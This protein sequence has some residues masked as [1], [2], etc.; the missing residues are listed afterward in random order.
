M[1]ADKKDI[2]E[3][4]GIGTTGHEWDG[5]KELDNPLPRWWLIIFYAT[6]AIS[7]VYWVMMPAWPTLDGFTT[8]VRNYSD[9]AVVRQELDTL[10]AQRAPRFEK[11]MQITAEDAE[12]DPDLLNFARAAGKA[13]FGDNCATCH[14]S[15]AQGAQGYP[16]LNDNV[17]IWG[18]ALSDI[19]TTIRYG[20]RSPHPDTRFSQM[21]AF[22]ADQLLDKRQIA[23]VTEHVI[24]L[25][26]GPGEPRAA[27]R[28]A[29]T[30]AEQC[31][32]CHGATGGGDRT[33]GAP[34]LTTGLYLKADPADVAAKNWPRLRT[35]IAAQIHSGSGGVM[36]AWES[37]LDPATVR[38]VAIY[39]HSLGGG[40]AS[41]TPEPP[42]PE[43]Q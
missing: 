35:A 21:P 22:G 39:I 7:V 26:G 32:A 27:A 37:R 38:A 14:G 11:L 15:G 2:D 41:P 28:G 6:I 4:T 10:Q 12:R 31:A 8:G 36:P 23:D 42:T 3:V 18:G 43:A 40:E 9:R 33:Q 13:A 16:N 30:F 1:S 25:A 24:A 17:W 20:I 34:D 5:I 29:V 19:E